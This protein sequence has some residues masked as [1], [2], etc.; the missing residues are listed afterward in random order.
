MAAKF[1][2]LIAFCR[3]FSRFLIRSVDVLGFRRS[4]PSLTLIPYMSSVGIYFVDVL[5]ELLALKIISNKNFV[6]CISGYAVKRNRKVISI[7]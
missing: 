3:Y 6:Y 5:S 7:I 1:S 4:S 2:A